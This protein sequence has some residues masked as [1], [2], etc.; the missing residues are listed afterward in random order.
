MF[1]YFEGAI[2]RARRL[3]KAGSELRSAAMHIDWIAR[4]YRG[5]AYLPTKKQTTA[6]MPMLQSLSG[7]QGISEL[8]LLAAD[9]GRFDVAAAG[10]RSTLEWA[11]KQ[12]GVLVTWHP[13]AILRLAEI[14]LRQLHDAVSARNLV[15]CAL[16]FRGVFAVLED[17]KRLAGLLVALAAPRV[18]WAEWGA[19][20]LRHMDF[21]TARTQLFENELHDETAVK[22]AL[23]Q[24]AASEE[25]VR[26]AIQHGPAEL[27]PILESLSPHMGKPRFAR[28]VSNRFEAPKPR[29]A[30]APV[31]ASWFALDAL[32]L[33]YFWYDMLNAAE[34]EFVRNGDWALFCTPTSDFSMG[35]AQWWRTLES[36]LKHGIAMKLSTLFSENK[37]WVEWDKAHLS[38]NQ[39]NRDRSLWLRVADRKKALQLTLGDLVS[40]LEQC[41]S[42]DGLTNGTGSKLRLEAARLLERDRERVQPLLQSEWLNPAHLTKDNVNLFRNRASHNVQLPLVDAAVGRCLAN[43]VLNVF[44]LPVLRSRGFVPVLL[45]G[46]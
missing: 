33:R 5:G 14:A 6:I 30:A 39:L 23:E 13:V 9:I 27:I 10:I 31:D 26:D 29:V 12:H 17:V 4:I 3:Q 41:T 36:V 34:Q 24:D 43:R 21:A 32:R 44:F 19:I 46:S 16:G 35:L 2:D 15:N 7:G 18:L 22:W 45:C 25:V 1:G 11:L 40:I 38:A 20:L 28:I 8:A 42:E 37:E